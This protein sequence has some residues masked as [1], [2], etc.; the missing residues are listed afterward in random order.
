MLLTSLVN[1]DGG[2][3]YIICATVWLAYYNGVVPTA[4]N[5]ILLVICAVFGSI[6]TAPVPSALIVLFITTYS[7]VFGTDPAGM[8]Y[9]VAIDWLLDRITTVFNVCG[10]LS[11][12]CLVA[13][14]MN[15]DLARKEHEVEDTKSL[16]SDQCH[17]QDDDDAK[18]TIHDS[19]KG[20]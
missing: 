20:I 15:K 12:A 17:K 6:G 3:I 16:K 9:I 5:Y 8:S 10:D 4:A 18:A 7:T 1:M 13:N 19:V 11:V 2:T 14:Q